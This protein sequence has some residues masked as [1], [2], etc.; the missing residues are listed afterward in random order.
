MST[1]VW[2]DAMSR[3]DIRD[4]LAPTAW[5]SWLSIAT[6]WALVFGSFALV[7]VWPNPLTILVALFV[8]GARQL[9]FAILMHEAAHHTLFHNRRLNDWAG[10][11]LCAFPVWSD[12]RPYRPYHLQHHARTWTAEDPDIGL[13]MPFPITRD[14]LRRKVWR[15]LSGQTGWK[16]LKAT[17]R[18]DLGRSKGRVSRNFDAGIEALWGVV[19]TNLVLLAVLALAGHP[20][21]YLLWVIAWFTTYSLVMRIR[22]IAEHAMVSEP[23]TDLGQTRTTVARW[24]ER[25]LIAPNFVNYHLEHHLLMTVPHYNLPGMHRLL[26]ERGVLEQACIAHGYR[27]VLGLAASKAA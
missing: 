27:E 4:L 19:L 6:N 24:W 2:R 1:A 8:I 15:D 17:F 12:I 3:D 21:L 13:V 20:A 23:S 7:A 9:G 5:K 11:W 22:S 10:N 18:R 25:L 16:R 26:R 14:S